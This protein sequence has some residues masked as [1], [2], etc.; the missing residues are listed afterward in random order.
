MADEERGVLLAF[1]E[2][3]YNATEHNCGHAD[4][5]MR[6]SVDFGKT[7]GLL[8]KVADARHLHEAY[9]EGA[10]LTTPWCATF[11]SDL[12]MKSARP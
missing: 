2:G 11:I 5:V 4:L 8:R 3:R 6:R 12:C 10:A 7:W 9:I 1:A